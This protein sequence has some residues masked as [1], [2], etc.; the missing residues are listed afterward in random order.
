MKI[1]LSPAVQTYLQILVH[2]F[3]LCIESL[4]GSWIT[5][6]YDK[7]NKQTTKYSTRWVYTRDGDK[8]SLAVLT[9]LPSCTVSHLTVHQCMVVLEPKSY[10]W[11]LILITNTISLSEGT[12]L[13]FEKSILT[14]VTYCTYITG[15]WSLLNL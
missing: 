9:S 14:P 8:R 13:S 4:Y 12:D 2:Y 11:G 5:H 3:G 10:K 15:V 1:Q 7:L 6:R